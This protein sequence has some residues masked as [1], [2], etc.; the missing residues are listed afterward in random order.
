ML[1]FQP[2]TSDIINN[3]NLSGVLGSP[4][5]KKKKNLPLTLGKCGL[6]NA[7]IITRGGS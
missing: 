1:I 5:K 2:Q 6:M 3:E 7:Q 4:K